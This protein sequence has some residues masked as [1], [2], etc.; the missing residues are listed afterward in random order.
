MNLKAKLDKFLFRQPEDQMNEQTD[1]ENREASGEN[2]DD[3][4]E[5]D[6]LEKPEDNAVTLKRKAIAGVAMAAGVFIVVSIASNSVK[7]KEQHKQLSLETNASNSDPASKLPDKYG[8]LN[9]YE[10]SLNKKNGKT[11]AVNGK[12]APGT[13]QGP[14]NNVVPSSPSYSAG[15]RSGV[16]AGYDFSSSSS[17]GGGTVPLAS[18][19]S[20]SSSSSSNEDSEEDKAAAKAWSDMVNSALSFKFTSDGQGTDQQTMAQ[21]M[22][23]IN[24]DSAYRL[25]AGTV[26]QATLLTGI[27][28]DTPNGDVVA[29]VRQNIYDTLTGE[30]L[31]IPQGSRLIGKSGSAGSRGN[32]RLGVVFK[33]IIF[34]NGVSV[35]LPD[36][37][38]IDG[39]GYPGLSD[40]YDD[41]AS[42]IYRSAFMSALFSAAAQA[43]TGNTSGSDDRSPGQEAVAGAAASVLQTG[44]Q[45]VQQDLNMQP[46]ISVRPGFQF[47]VFIN[48]DFSLGEYD[49][50]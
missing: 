15:S 12:T 1:E 33:R 2:Q 4:I 31:L 20:S 19:S 34:P 18:A 32:K 50:E 25:D 5:V 9:K 10:A 48:Q 3:D 45:I 23:A 6:D 16:S 14:V 36:Q 8:D 24:G 26:I 28:S 38:A 47:S 41:H 21:G 13:V 44:Q 7:P 40:Q 49:G 39:V 43:A 22:T 42:S 46:T 37:N 29:Q 30:H 27:T 11:P 35:N 17:G